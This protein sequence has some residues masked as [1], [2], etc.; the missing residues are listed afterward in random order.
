MNST[1]TNTILQTHDAEKQT[2]LFEA[3]N[4]TTPDL[5][6]VFDLDYRFIYANKALLRMWGRT[7]DE[8]VGRGLRE[9]GYEEWHADMH[10]REIDTVVATKAPIRGVVSFPHAT[11][12]KRIYDYIFSPVLNSRGEVEAIAGTTRD[13]SDIKRQSWP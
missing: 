10:E 1:M 6:Y 12:G 8:S 2:R 3:I 13:I 9:L 5:V 4:D 7:F 11:L